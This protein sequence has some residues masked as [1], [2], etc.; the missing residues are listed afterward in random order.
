MNSEEYKGL[1]KEKIL[2]NYN[3]NDSVLTEAKIYDSNDL[4]IVTA[5]D[6][7]RSYGKIAYFKVYVYPSNPGPNV[8]CARIHVMDAKYEK[9]FWPYKFIK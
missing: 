4:I 7:N 9:T 2:Y 8:P 1:L 5:I 3:K 6:P